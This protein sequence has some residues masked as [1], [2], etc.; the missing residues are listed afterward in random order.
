[1]AQ[2]YLKYFT[3]ASGS[4]LPAVWPDEIRQILAADRR[5]PKEIALNAA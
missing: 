3:D 4:I 5:R 2:T 1:V